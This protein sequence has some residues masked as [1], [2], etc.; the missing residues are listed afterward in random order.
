MLSPVPLPQDIE[1]LRLIRETL[2][3]AAKGLAPLR[4][5]MSPRD[6][7]KEV[8]LRLFDERGFKAVT[9]RDVMEVQGLTAGAMYN[10]FRSKELLL[11]SLITDSVGGLEAYLRVA[12]SVS[13]PENRPARL[14]A[15]AYAHARYQCEYAPLARVSS[16]EFVHLPAKAK[17]ELVP[18]LLRIRLHQVGVTTEGIKSGEFDIENPEIAVMEFQGMGAKMSEWYDIKGPFDPARMSRYHAKIVLRIVGG[19]TSEAIFDAL[20]NVFR[21]SRRPTVRNKVEAAV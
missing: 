3:G 17:R 11:V 20:D 14:A 16:N 2:P 10:H 6:S 21:T 13:E 5:S 12:F 18:R 15:V 8:A 1:N 7:L 4:S 19:Q 9:V